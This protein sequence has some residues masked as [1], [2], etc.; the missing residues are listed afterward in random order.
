VSL[1]QITTE[2]KHGVLQ[3]PPP[4]LASPCAS[5][6]PRAVGGRGRR[7]ATPSL[8]EEGVVAD[9]SSRWAEMGMLGLG[10]KAALFDPPRFVLPEA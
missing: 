1:A 10:T 6:F 5:W 2:Q 9:P 4:P 8:R 3:T 7:R